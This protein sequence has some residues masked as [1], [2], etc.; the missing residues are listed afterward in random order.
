[1]SKSLPNFKHLIYA[2]TSS[3]YGLNETYPLSEDQTVCHPMQFYAVTKTTTELMAHSYASLFGIPSTGLRFFTVYGPWGRP[4]MALFKFTKNIIQE[5]SI[6]VYGYGKHIRAFTYVDD[7]VDGIL[8]VINKAPKKNLKFIKNPP[9]P[10]I[11]SAPYQILNIGGGQATNLL[12]FIN[13]IEKNVGKKAKLNFLDIQPGDILKTEASTSAIE[14]L[15][16][17]SRTNISDGVKNFVDWYI[18]YHKLQGKL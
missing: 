18:S 12:D 15:G 8:R 10:G 9:M 11:S 3:V 6:D 2:S 17:K 5:K 7:V 4:D 1:M 13:E 16:Y 14:K